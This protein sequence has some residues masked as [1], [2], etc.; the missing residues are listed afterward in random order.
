MS[1]CPASRNNVP[2]LLKHPFATSSLNFESEKLVQ[3][4]FERVARGR[5]FI[6]MAHLLATVQNI[7]VIFLLDEGDI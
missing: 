2:L 3:G 6:M 4:V 5:T 7:N 1:P